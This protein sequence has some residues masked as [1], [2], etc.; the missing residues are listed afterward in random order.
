M[1]KHLPRKTEALQETIESIQG[2]LFSF[3]KG[4]VPEWED[5][6]DILQEVMAQFIDHQDDIIAIEKTTSWL[7][8]VARN[9]ITDSYRKKRPTSFSAEERKSQKEGKEGPISLA[10]ILPDFSQ[11]PETMYLRAAILEELEEAMDELPEAQRT[12]FVMHEFE[13]K[14]FKEI[15][16]LTG[17]S[18]NTLLSRKRYAVLYLRDR[19]QELYNDILS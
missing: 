11:N 13:Q 16:L 17:D 15:A 2:R 5:A 4:R 14:S 7:F 3:I 1:S 18:V 19:L 10:E 8:T 6:E 12:V 9:K